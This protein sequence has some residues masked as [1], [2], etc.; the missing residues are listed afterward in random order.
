MRSVTESPAQRG[1]QSGNGHVPLDPAGSSIGIDPA[2]S[3]NDETLSEGDD[4][5]ERGSGRHRSHGRPSRERRVNLRL[6]EGEYAALMEAAATA[7][8]TPA[9]FATEAALAAAR[10][11]G[12]PE[13]R[14]LRAML[15]ELM[16]ARTQ[17]RRYGVNIN[18]AVAQLQ[19]TGEAPGW[20]ERATAGADRAVA[21]VEAV[22]G[23]V[24]A[25]LRRRG[26]R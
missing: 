8:L 25:V 21:R 14:A 17:V 11:E 26:R 6:S 12:M 18:Q 24:A 4:A 13:H 5:E 20:L 9:G 16:A 15:V 2:G 3:A 10:G 1:L 22:A 23:E 19:A 7:G